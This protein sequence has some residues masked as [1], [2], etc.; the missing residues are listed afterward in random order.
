MI[1]NDCNTKLS[2]PLPSMRKYEKCY[3]AIGKYTALK[4]LLK[5]CNSFHF[6][7]MRLVLLFWLKALGRRDVAI[8]GVFFH[9]FC[10]EAQLLSIIIN[11]CGPMRAAMAPGQNTSD[12][13]ILRSFI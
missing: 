6:P 2:L 8:L 5:C 4:C 7:T 1:E 3:T 11:P 10:C 13:I 9:I 12:E